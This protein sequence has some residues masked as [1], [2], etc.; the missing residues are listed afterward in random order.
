[1]FESIHKVSVVMARLEQRPAEGETLME[2]SEPK[3]IRVPSPPLVTPVP[4]VLPLV[5]EQCDATTQ[6]ASVG[7]NAGR[8]DKR[9]G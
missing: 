5:V 8:C 2:S 9:L 1:M 6:D 7:T 4:H 3:H